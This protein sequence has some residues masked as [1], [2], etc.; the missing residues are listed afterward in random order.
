[1]K[2]FLT[3][4]RSSFTY[5]NITQFLGALNDNIFKLL[6]IFF[7]IHLEGQEASNTILASAGAIFVLPF[8]LFLAGCGVLADRFSKRNII[9]ISKMLEVIVMCLG[10]TALYFESKYGAYTILFL[11]ATQSAIFGP[12]KYGIV[13]EIVESERISAANGLLSSFTYFAIIVGTF[14]ASFVTDITDRS[15]VTVSVLC[16]LISIVGLAT[17]LRIEYTPPSGSVKKVSPFFIREVYHSIRVAKKENSLVVA[18]FGSAYFLFCGAYLQL[19]MIPFAIQ[20]LG[21]DEIKGGYLFLVTALGI[22]T[23]SMFAGWLSGKYVELGLVPLGGFG[24]AMCGFGLD[25]FS[26][27]LAGVMLIVFSV[28]LMGGIYVVPLDSFIQMASPNQHRGQI[29]AASG[30]LAF[31]GV[32]AASIML[33]VVND[34]LGFPADKGFTMVGWTT[35]FITLALTVHLRDYAI[36]FIG[37]LISRIGFEVTVNGKEHVP[38]GVPTVLICPYHSWSD[39]FMVLG[40]QRQR[41]HFFVEC[42]KGA[43]LGL[44]MLRRF[45][46]ITTT[47]ALDPENLNDKT[48]KRIRQAL[49]KGRSVCIFLDQASDPLVEELT[50]SYQEMLKETPYATVPVEITKNPKSYPDYGVFSRLL[51]IIRVPAAININEG[52]KVS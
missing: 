33:K 24:M 20:S 6:I 21:L 39:S 23:G 45:L 3:A 42:R 14:L 38:A 47:P 28:G 13:P 18:M 41:I 5:L 44:K 49:D 51:R 31:L 34:I 19:N 22:G 15:F 17:S 46:K 52:R 4:E 48:A 43:S 12:S 9:V 32:L 11:M 1:M 25:Y 16:V 30:F 40:M 36:R 35:L 50:A 37:M 2:K 29:V 10:L 26:E 8:L 27:S 7:L